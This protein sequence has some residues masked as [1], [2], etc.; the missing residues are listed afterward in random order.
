MANSK[1]PQQLDWDMAQNRWATIIE[2]FLDRPANNSNILKNIDIQIGVNIINHKLGRKLQGW[3]VT[4]MRN[5][6]AQLYDEQDTNAF[7]NRTLILFSS[8]V[9]NIDLEVF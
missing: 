6:F 5:A 4:R 1:L 9:T 3:Q 7:P 8:A 2:P